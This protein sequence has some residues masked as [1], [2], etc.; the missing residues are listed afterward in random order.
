MEEGN[1]IQ[2]IQAKLFIKRCL[3]DEYM[4]KEAKIPKNKWFDSFIFDQMFGTRVAQ[5]KKLIDTKFK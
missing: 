2:S 3:L 1:S 4:I 5:I